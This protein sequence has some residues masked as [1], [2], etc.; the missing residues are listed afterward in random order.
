M[1]CSYSISLEPNQQLREEERRGGPELNDSSPAEPP[2]LSVD[3]DERRDVISLHDLRDERIHTLCPCLIFIQRYIK[4]HLSVSL[5]C[6]KV[7]IMCFM[8][9]SLAEG[10]IV[11]AVK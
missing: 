8:C 1:W 6:H 7:K 4:H 11:T 10:H 2:T 9:D 5:M 3:G